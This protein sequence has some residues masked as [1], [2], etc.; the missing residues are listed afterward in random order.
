MA[1]RPGDL[2]SVY[3]ELFAACALPRSVLI[4][5]VWPSPGQMSDEGEPDREAAGAAP[6]SP[7]PSGWRRGRRR[8]GRGRGRYGRR[9][10][11][12]PAGRSRGGRQAEPAVYP[13]G[14]PAGRLPRARAQLVAGHAGGLAAEPEHAVPRTRSQ[15]DQHTR[16]ARHAVRLTPPETGEICRG[17]GA[18][19][20]HLS[21][22]PCMSYIYQKSG[23]VNIST[24]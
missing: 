23:L 21:M 6:R 14:E 11:L 5:R 9:G 8:D 3:D 4:S 24:T 17:S 22:S 18:D 1:P 13:G 7:E 12:S 16:H 10:R 20:G 15:E 19:T 2:S